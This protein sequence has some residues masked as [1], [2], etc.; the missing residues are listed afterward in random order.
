MSAPSYY[1]AHDG[2]TD[3]A[4]AWEYNSVTGIA[5][6]RFVLVHLLQDGGTYGQISPSVGAG[7]LEDL[8][9]NEDELT[10]LGS[11]RSSYNGDVI[12]HIWV[13]RSYSSSPHTLYG[14]NK[15]SQDVYLREYEFNG[16]NTGSRIKDVIDAPGWEALGAGGQGMAT[17][18]RAASP[19]GN[20]IYAVAHDGDGTTWVSVGDY[21]GSYAGLWCT[22]APTGTWTQNTSSGWGALVGLRGVACDGSYWVIVGA[23]ADYIRYASDPTGAWSVPSSIGGVNGTLQAVVKGGSYW[24]T[25]GFGGNVRYATDPTGTWSEPSSPGFGGTDINCLAYDGTYWVAGANGGAMR[26]ATDPTGTWSAVS[27]P[28]FG[29]DNIVSVACNDTYWVAVD[30]T[31][32]ARYATDP[33]GTWSAIG[34]LIWAD[35]ATSRSVC[36]DGTTWVIGSSKGGVAWQTDPSGIWKTNCEHSADNV[37][38]DWCWAET[39]ADHP[40]VAMASDG[41][42]WLFATSSSCSSQDKVGFLL[43]GV[44]KKAAVGTILLDAPTTTTGPARLVLNLV[45]V[46]DDNAV[47]PFEYETGGNWVEAVAEYASSSGT[48]G[49][50]Q[51]QIARPS[52]VPNNPLLAGDGNATLYGSGGLS[53]E[54]AQSFTTSGAITVTG[55]LLGVGKVGSPTDNLVAQIYTNSSG[56]PSGTTVGTSD[57]IAGA[58]LTTSTQWLRFDVAASLSASTKYWVVLTR[59]GSRDTDNYFT[60]RFDATDVVSGEAKAT[61]SS[62]TWTAD[63]L[64]FDFGFAV[65]T[66]TED[67][68]STIGD[69]YSTMAASDPFLVI[70]F[71][72]K[73]PIP[74]PSRKLL[75]IRK[76]LQAINRANTY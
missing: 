35:S 58:D 66:A 72:L 20:S 16:V 68:G 54:F 37:D 3:A 51:L 74:T 14:S 17:I 12:Q 29:T 50:I 67:A 47:D 45:A 32:E 4:G 69:G 10:Y 56:V 70:G 73:G 43:P 61:R 59:S 5:V 57:A 40:I 18:S 42:L 2:S 76:L 33:T 6:D 9:G 23:A 31:G 8:A 62:G 25:V 27:S 52:A 55:V 7:T 46:G 26:Y 44:A 1:L 34:Q 13:G 75:P 38:L 15:G 63:G 39:P 53:E 22:N 60:I 48:D 65:L 49:C 28:G 11:Y 71:S 19:P 30:S 36:T 64:G 41:P 24:V 21:Y